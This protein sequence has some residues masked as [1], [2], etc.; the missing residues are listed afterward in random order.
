MKISKK[1]IRLFIGIMMLISLFGCNNSNIGNTKEQIN[2]STQPQNGKI[3]EIDGVK[4]EDNKIVQIIEEVGV[5][6]NMVDA[7]RTY[8]I[9]ESVIDNKN[10]DK[11]TVVVKYKIKN[12]NTFKVDNYTSVR[13]FVTNTG[14]K[15][16]LINGTYDIEIGAKE[17]IEEYV[18][19]NLSKTKP[20]ELK[21]LK[22][23]WIIG[24]H[25]GEEQE[26]IDDT[27]S[28]VK[29]NKFDIILE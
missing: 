5:F 23:W 20:E 29:D 11:T 26:I 19:F 24:Y 10:K 9:C 8:K 25:N 13:P 21:S 6:N 14:E 2:N 18:V 17:T 27:N 4:S 22:M 12:D 3:Y 7:S 28:Y 15:G 1:I 16:N